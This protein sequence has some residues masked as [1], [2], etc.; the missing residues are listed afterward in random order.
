M[1]DMK[2]FFFNVEPLSEKQ[3]PSN[4]LS[5]GVTFFTERV[6]T[7]GV[8]FGVLHKELFDTFFCMIEFAKNL[9]VK[10]TF[11]VVVFFIRNKNKSS[12]I[13]KFTFFCCPSNYFENSGNRLRRTHF[14]FFHPYWERGDK[15]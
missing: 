2:T 12:A 10:T 13:E 1:P 14:C 9:F 7:Q 5:I 11:F 15:K 6:S 8:F 4:I 3:T